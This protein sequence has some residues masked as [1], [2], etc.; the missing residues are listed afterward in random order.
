MSP[1]ELWKKIS[2]RFPTPADSFEFF[3]TFSSKKELKIVG[4]DLRNEKFNLRGE[5]TASVKAYGK[6]SFVDFGGDGRKRNVIEL[7]M[8]NE[9]C[10]FTQAVNIVANWLN[11]DTSKFQ[12]KVHK[13]ED[14]EKKAPPYKDYYVQK[15]IEERNKPENILLFK[16]LCYGLFRGC[17]DV[18]IRNGIKIFKIGFNTYKN[19]EDIEESRLFIP[20]YDENFVP[21]GSY[22]YNRGI[23]SRKGLL[24]KNCQRVLFGSHLMKN[25]KDGPIIMSEGHSDVV[26]NNAKNLRCLTTGSSTK[27]LGEF[28]HLL[29]GKELHFY[30]DA[31]QPGIKG[32]TLKALEIEMFNK[33][34]PEEEKIKYKMFLWGAWKETSI[35]EFQSLY[36]PLAAV[37]KTDALLKYSKAWWLNHFDDISLSP[38]ITLSIMELEQNR[39]LA[40]KAK[41]LNISLDQKILDKINIKKWSLLSKDILD[42]GFDFID[43]HLKNN[44]SERY[45]RFLSKYKN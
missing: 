21:Y 11:E 23:K 20:E 34:L 14:D 1:V 15:Q 18:E 40:D 2:E 28:L 19:S 5:D 25:F 16:E 44:K 37:G 35:E 26:V 9:G 30:P 29:K 31:D 39:I 3:K 12:T 36:L 45:D 17:S 4:V 32:V 33:T 43:F 10:N 13:K 38:I 27:S 24:R 6:L 7:I 42:Q 41:E 8:Q 22:R